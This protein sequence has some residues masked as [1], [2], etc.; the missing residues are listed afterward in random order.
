[1]LYNMFCGDGPLVPERIFD[2][3][4]LYMSMVAILVI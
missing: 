4:L 1:M 3:F 2:G